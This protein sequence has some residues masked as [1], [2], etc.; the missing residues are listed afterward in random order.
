MYAIVT[1]ILE[2]CTEKRYSN[3]LYL[4]KALD[5]MEA[6]DALTT[7]KIGQDIVSKP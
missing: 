6:I 7:C 5:I 4:L 1:E 2:N 3:S